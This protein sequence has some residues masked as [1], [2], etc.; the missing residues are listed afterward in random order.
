M[1]VNTGKMFSFH[2]LN[3]KF[4]SN[5]KPIYERH[6]QIQVPKINPKF[7]T[8]SKDLMK[9]NYK[10]FVPRKTKTGNV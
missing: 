3:Q 4:K 7:D 8:L 6:T 1:V 9:P 2:A 5:F 10:S